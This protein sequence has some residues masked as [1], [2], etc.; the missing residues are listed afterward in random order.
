MTNASPTVR[1]RVD[2]R[3]SDL[4][5]LFPAGVELRHADPTIVPDREI[6]EPEDPAESRMIEERRLQFRVGRTLA[7]RAT[8][9]LGFG[10]APIVT[11]P[12]GAPVWPAGAVG[13]ITHCR[14]LVIAIAARATEF[15]GVGVDAEIASRGSRRAIER[16]V[17]TR[18]EGDALRALP[19][20]DG[21]RWPL[22]VFSA[23]ESIYKALALPR[24]EAPGFRD[25]ELVIDPGRA[26]YRVRACDPDAPWADV[27]TRLRGGFVRTGTVLVTSAYIAARQ[28]DAAAS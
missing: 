22:V 21:V 20:I 1:M 6:L 15:A 4:R 18:A 2:A 28:P 16:I 17:C 25:V 19:D 14:D 12:E 7:R 27:L 3:E 13:A 5:A 8:E 24:A 11:G 10:A 23:K 9:A 26:S